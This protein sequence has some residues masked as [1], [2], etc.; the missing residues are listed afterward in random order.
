[1]ARSVHQQLADAEARYQRL[2]AQA[3]AVD[4]RAETHRKVV[5]GAA[6]LNLVE[7]LPAQR[8][9]ELLA[10][11]HRHVTRPSD[12]ERFG[13][14]PLVEERPRKPV[15]RRVEAGPKGEP[16]NNAEQGMLPM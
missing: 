12:R 2:K 13:L 5:Y 11:V 3:K 9:D 1:M 16:I 7:T 8:R 10:S 14:P 15:P 4:N 6:F